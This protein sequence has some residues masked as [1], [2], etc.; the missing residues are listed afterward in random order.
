MNII[1]TRWISQ[2][3]FH[4]RRPPQV[5][6]FSLLAS[7]KNN[8]IESYSANTELLRK[9]CRVVVKKPEVEFTQTYA[10]S[11]R[12]FEPAHEKQK[13]IRKLKY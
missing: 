7:F 9:K 5:C 11:I 3:V 13:S 10:C 1:F 4:L 8:F 12:N 2:C 6:L